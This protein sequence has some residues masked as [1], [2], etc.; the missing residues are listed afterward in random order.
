MKRKIINYT[1]GL[2]LTALL[3]LPGCGDD[4]LDVVDPTVLSTNAYPNTVD[5]LEIIL[6]DLYGRLRDGTYSAI[7]RSLIL[8]DHSN[9]H[10]Y[11]GAEFNE[12]ALNSLN[13]DLARLS[14]FWLNQF[15]HIAKCNDFMV[16]L[17]RIKADPKW[18]AAQQTRFSQMEAECRYLRAFCYF[19]LVN[20]FGEDPI[21][22]E[23]DKSKMGVPL[24]TEIATTIAGTSKERATQ[25]Q[26]Y[27]FIISELEACVPLITGAGIIKSQNAR[28]NEWAVKTLLAKSYI[29]TLQFSKAQPILKNIIDNSGKTL[30][31]YL[32]YR[33]MYGGKNEFNSESIW[34]VNYTRDVQANAGTTI[35]GNRYTNYVAIT[36]DKNGVE[37]ING[38]ANFFFH[39]RNVPRL[40][41][42]DTTY[43][44]SKQT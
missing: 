31:P 35:T 32:T 22:T 6:N 4:F 11:N 29:Y 1:I 43:C 39:D 2:V 19:H 15:T 12:F 30:V 18:T 40:G 3:I 9:D 25:G 24:W 20:Q 27:D 34:E 21:L 44:I 14:N 37:T 26:I 38:F 23:A 36:F 28:V 41:F 7:N 5:D 13:P 8:I 42:D 16:Q 10:G 33:N 17:T